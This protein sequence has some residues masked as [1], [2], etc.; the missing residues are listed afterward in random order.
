M[1]KR[2]DAERLEYKNKTKISLQNFKKLQNV[3]EKLER[4][5]LELQKNKE[6]IK[7]WRLFKTEQKDLL[8]QRAAVITE[9]SFVYF[10]FIM[11][12]FYCRFFLFDF[13]LADKR[14]L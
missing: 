11:Y 3:L 10:L 12:K 8:V 14:F 4:K 7:K 5:E 13:F 1:S 6:K 9:V 2:E